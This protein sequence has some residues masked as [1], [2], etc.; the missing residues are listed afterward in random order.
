MY[1]S[2]SFPNAGNLEEGFVLRVDH[3]PSACGRSTRR[4]ETAVKEYYTA[5][6]GRHRA[7]AVDKSKLEP[8]RC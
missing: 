8:L 1:R 2:A 4:Q 7:Q 3:L 6:R 5:L